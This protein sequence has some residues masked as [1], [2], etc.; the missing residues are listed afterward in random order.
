MNSEAEKVYIIYAGSRTKM[1]R[2]YTSVLKVELPFE[3]MQLR[4]V[5]SQNSAQH[6]I[7]V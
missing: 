1:K 7:D 4:T 2:K 6:R 3:D 5:A